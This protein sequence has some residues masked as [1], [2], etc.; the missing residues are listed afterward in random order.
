MEIFSSLLIP[1]IIL[2][3]VIYG[4][5]KKIDVYDSFVKGAID[6]LKAAW[7]IL[8]YIIGIFLA[9]GIF[10]TGKG[11]DM[12]EWLFTPIANMMSIPKE[13]IGLISVKPLSGSGALGMYSELA[14]RVG[15]GSLVEKMGATIV[16]SSETIF[17]TMAIYYGSLKIKNTRH[18]LSCAMI[19]HV[20]GVI[21]AVFIC[22]VIF[23]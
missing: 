17:Y 21:A 19:S 7:D 12:L 4:K 20:A 22:Y 1:I 6:G 11:L 15:I 5:Y 13:L 23:V 10:K 18:T 2:Y 9:I 8:P 3:I 14:N 16:G